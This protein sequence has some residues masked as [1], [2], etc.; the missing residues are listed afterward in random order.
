LRNVTPTPNHWVRLE[1]E[2]SRHRNPAGS[3]RD[4]VGAIVTVRAGGRTLVR[5]LAGGGSY[6][7]SHDRRILI[8]LGAADRVDEVSVKWPNAAGTVQRFG[9]MTADR[10]YNLIEG[11]A[12]VQ[13]A[14]APL[15][16]PAR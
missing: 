15:V 2:G 6:Y 10:S 5:Y 13:P 8:G 7:S 11:T 9:P 1:L 3:N 14:L 4:A 12:E 16:R